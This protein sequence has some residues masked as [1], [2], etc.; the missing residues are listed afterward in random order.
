MKDYKIPTLNINKFS[1]KEFSF[2]SFSARDYRKLHIV[3]ENLIK[4]SDLLEEKHK[5]GK[6][7]GSENYMKKSKYRFL[8]TVNISRNY[9]LD[10]ASIEYC[11]PENKVFPKKNEILIVKDGAGN[12]LGEVALYSYDNKENFDS[13]SAGII[14]I[15]VKEDFRFYVLGILKSQ[16]FKDYIDINTAQGSTIRHAKLIALDYKI[17]FPTINN[18]QNPEKI[19]KLVSIITQNIIDKEEKIN[20]KN[21]KIDELIEK[22]L[23]ENQKSENN[24]KYAYP[25]ISEI[26]KESRL[27]TG[28][29]EREFKEIDFL[30]RNYEG[31]YINFED[32]GFKRKKGPN[33]AISVIGRSYYSDIKHNQNFKQ[34]ILSKHVTD[35]GGLK[36]NQY[37]GSSAK[38]PILKKFDFLLFARGDIGR[39]ILIDDILI[40]ATSNFDVF[41]ISSK[42]QNWENI[43][44]LCYFKYLRNIGFWEFYG[45]GGSGASS[46][47]DYYFKK[48]N[49]P[50]FPDSKQQE[51]AKEYYNKINKNQNLNLDNYLELEKARNDQLGIFQLNMEIFTLREKL[52]DII[53]KIIND[54]NI[55]INLNY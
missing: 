46:L 36:A 24:F 42:K 2:Y 20:E 35:E 1:D 29:Y 15:D 30:I 19:E 40:G 51:I 13:L 33:L 4:L 14:A 49:L 9:T 6:E 12:G 39:V 3:N 16:H 18:N 44:A 34:L 50:N 27:D 28:I 37:I 7:I 22:E 5:A 26:K 10:E 8:K 45:V 48:V 11:K 52:E 53:D 21:K 23:R 38:L 47:T 31:G 43:F 17:P 32:S 41:F 55:N 25:K 54:Q